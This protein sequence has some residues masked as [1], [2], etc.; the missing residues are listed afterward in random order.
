V[1]RQTRWVLLTYRLP[2][3]PSTPHISLWRQLRRLG[4]AQVADGV[5]ALPMDARTREQLEW[6]AEEVVEAGGDATIWFAEPGSAAH[7]RALAQQIADAVKSSQAISGAGFVNAGAARLDVQTEAR[8][9]LDDAVEVLKSVVVSNENGLPVRIG[10]VADVVVAD[11]PRVGAAL[12]DGKP[13]VF[14][15]VTKL[16]WADTIEVTKAVEQ[17]MG[18]LALALPPNAVLEAPTVVGIGT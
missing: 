1:Y 8:L 18:E 15:Q 5:V 6:L 13:A 11:E 2:R 9:D 4:V 10:E 17:A 14:I 16:P 12:F 3:E 7:E